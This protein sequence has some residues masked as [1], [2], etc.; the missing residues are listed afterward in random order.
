MSSD[1]PVLTFNELLIRDG[2]DPA[3][4]I[5]F[6][7]RPTEPEL[8][9]NFDWIVAERP[10]LFD[11]YQN[12]HN[13]RTEAALKKASFVASFIRRSSGEALYIGTY[14]I[15]G[16]RELTPNEWESRP[17]QLELVQLGMAGASGGA[18]RDSVSEFDL[19]LTSF[20]SSWRRRLIIAWPGGERS[21]YRWADRN[22]FVV[23]AVVEADALRPSMPAWDEIHLMHGELGIL[24]SSWCDALCHWRGVYLIVDQSDRR[25]Y[26]GSAGGHENLLQRWRDYGRTGHGGNK[27]LRDRDPTQFVFSIL[28][29][30]SPDLPK[31]ELVAIENSWKKRIGSIWPAG[32]NQN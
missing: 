11:C 12:T 2:I 21:W 25:C 13:E 31:D 5:V 16:W 20:L 18:W 1:I 7:H 17:P 26:V 6:R 8:N 15:A 30:V 22:I 4:T 3:K 10:D 24:P 9:R 14:E 28:Q 29:R 19:K 27:Y 32:L 23:N